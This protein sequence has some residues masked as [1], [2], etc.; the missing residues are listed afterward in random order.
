ML[1]WLKDPLIHFFVLGLVVFGLYSVAERK[2]EPAE[3]PLLVAVTSAEIEWY[4]TMWSKQMGRQPTIEELRGQ[5]NQ[6]IREQILSRE[7]VSMG[8][9]DG[10]TVVRRRLAQKMDFLFKDLSGMR[11]PTENELRAFLKENPGNY[12]TPGRMSFTQVYFSTDKRGDQE[13]VEAAEQLV[14]RLNREKNVPKDVSAL[15]DPFLLQPVYSNKT[16]SDIRR[17]FGRVFAENAWNLALG[18]WQGPLRSG[19]G[20]HAVY[21]HER[22][23]AALPG[24]DELKDALTADWMAEKQR[25]LAGRAYEKLRRQ[26]QVL[27][28]GMPYDL[29]IVTDDAF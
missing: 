2:K 29:D 18:T 28:E 6:L 4:R 25:A 21:V 14:E 22:L 17:E 8:L 13:A 26:Y 20:M 11:E 24:F 3:N 5:V 1:N 7:A 10:D 19:Y 16:M 23:D 12:E 15:G 9:D 27:V